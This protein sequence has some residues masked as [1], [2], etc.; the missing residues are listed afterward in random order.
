M[1]RRNFLLKS[2]LFSVTIGAPIV[3]SANEIFSPKSSS[4]NDFGIQLYSVREEMEKNPKATLKQLAKFGYKNLEGYE[5]SK[6]LFWGMSN[7]E[8]KKYIEGLGLKMIASHCNETDNLESFRF[9]CSQA[10]E[11]GMDYLICPWVGGERNMVTFLKHADTFNKCGQIAKSN[12]IKFAFHNHDYTFKKDKGAFL[13]DVLMRN[14][15]PSLVDFEMDIYWVVVA[16]EDPME[17]FDKYPNRFKYC[18]IKDYLKLENGHETCTLGTGSIDFQ[19]IISY[20]ANKGLETFIVEQE[21]YRGS[22]PMEAA[23][24][25][26]NYMEKLRF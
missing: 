10:A 4:L 16:G 7:L 5:G 1:N 25:N 19:K 8:F 18:H 3:S 24:D 9:K 23:K 20:G 15:D 6:G 2:I 26:L 21:S 14:T 13:Q 22:S 12:G 17:W 11:V